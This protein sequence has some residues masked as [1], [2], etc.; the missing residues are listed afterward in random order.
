MRF[1]LPIAAVV[2]AV[3]QAA[4]VLFGTFFEWWW[5]AIISP[6]GIVSYLLLKRFSSKP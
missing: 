3:T 5:A 1:R 2:L 4:A 6:V